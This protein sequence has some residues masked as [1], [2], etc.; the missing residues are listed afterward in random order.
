MKSFR[1]KD[2]LYESCV[3][4][5]ASPALEELG[6]VGAGRELEPRVKKHF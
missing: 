6:A 5:K 1:L 3:M 4:K 2:Y